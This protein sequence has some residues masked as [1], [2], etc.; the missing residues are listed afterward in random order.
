MEWL[1]V[2]EIARTTGIPAPTARRYASLF[3]E[4]LGGKKVGR[5]TRYPLPSVEVFRRVFGLYRD[6][7]LTPEIAATLAK[8]LPRVIDVPGPGP[9]G[10][11]VP[12]V[13]GAVLPQVLERLAC[14]LELVADQK[15]QVEDLREEIRKLKKAF[16]LLARSQK[17]FRRSRAAAPGAASP[18]P[19]R[20]VRSRPG[21]EPLL[22]PVP[23]DPER[24]RQLEE[25]LQRLRRERKDLDQT[26]KHKLESLG[27][28]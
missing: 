13:Q 23:A 18:A 28:R 16:V 11:A 3:R 2:A 22:P 4:F 15:R 8:D 17:E 1:S 19:S 12:A 24:I 26:L 10:L 21:E 9:G 25:E 6:G 5:T 20:D 14:H 7:L 27:G